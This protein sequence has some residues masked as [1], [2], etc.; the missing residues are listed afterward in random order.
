[1]RLVCYNIHKG[2][3]EFRR[4]TL[5]QLIKY[6]KSLDADVIC[7][8]EVLYYQFN[9]MKLIL[10]MDGVF[11]IHVHNK[12]MK[13]GICILSKEKIIKSNHILL[14]SKKEQRGI[15]SIDRENEVIINTHLGLDSEERKTQISEILN[16]AKNKGK[17]IIICGDFNEENI[18]LSSYKDVAK[19]LFEDRKATFNKWRID[20]IFCSKVTKVKS[21]QVDQVFYSDH[22]PIM[23]EM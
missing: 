10:K 5:L 23:I 20:Y 16:F 22:F 19:Y 2:M 18:N 17:N 12:K 11:A 9:M 13:F 21:Y 6:L 7:L 3:D 14:T 15:L 8:Q 1:M 4:V